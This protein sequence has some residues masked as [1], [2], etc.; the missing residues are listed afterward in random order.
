MIIEKVHT[1]SHFQWPD[2]G[3]HRAENAC[4][5]DCADTWSSKQ[6]HWLSKCHST[7]SS[8]TYYECEN[9]VQLITAVAWPSVPIISIH[10]WVDEESKILQL[11]GT[12]HNNGQMDHRQIHHGLCEISPTLT[13]V[14][15]EKVFIDLPLCHCC[16]QWHVWSHGW[17]YVSI[18]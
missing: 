14:D 15:V 10:L 3:V 11:P 2:N 17:H 9:T 5:I 13:H 7:T 6:V 12:L 8:I 16:L 4:C 18:G 1:S